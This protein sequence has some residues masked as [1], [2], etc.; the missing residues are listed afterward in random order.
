MIPIP[1]YPKD[2]KNLEYVPNYTIRGLHVSFP[3]VA[4]TNLWFNAVNLKEKVWI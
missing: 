4:R 2:I 1:Q 3:F